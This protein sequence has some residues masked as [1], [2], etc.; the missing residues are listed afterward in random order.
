MALG[1]VHAHG[2][3]LRAGGTH[4][5]WPGCA[6]GRGFDE[7]GEKGV[8]AGTVG[9]RGTSMRFVPLCKRRYWVLEA[10]VTDTSPREALER[11]M[12]DTAGE[13]ICRVVF[14]GEADGDGV[15]LPMVESMFRDR[16]YALELRD[17]TKPS[18]SLWEK[19]EENSLRGVFLQEM[20]KKYDAASDETAREQVVLALRFGLAAL[21]GRE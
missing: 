9:P 12:P 1:H 4:Y 17:K 6:E 18:Q 13:D 16:F 21:D 8:L 20:K 2:G 7:L 10:D 11:V 15:D 14:T 19:A 5:A 3:L